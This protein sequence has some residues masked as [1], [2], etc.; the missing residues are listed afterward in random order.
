[1]AEVV[2]TNHVQYRL[3]EREIDAHEA[4]KIAKDGKITKRSSD[5]SIIREGICAN[6]K[7]LFVVSILRGNKIL[8]ETAYYD[9][10]KIR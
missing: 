6:G 9:K 7:K 1:M 3:Y 8:I 5:G 10:N 4:I 2:L